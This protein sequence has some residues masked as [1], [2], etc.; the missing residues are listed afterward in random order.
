MFSKKYLLLRWFSK[1][2]RN[3][4]VFQKNFHNLACADFWDTTYTCYCWNDEST[5][6]TFPFD[7]FVTHINLWLKCYICQSIQIIFNAGSSFVFLQ[8]IF[9]PVRIKLISHWFEFHNITAKCNN[10]F[11]KINI[12][13]VRTYIIREWEYKLK[14]TAQ[15]MIHD[16]I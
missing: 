4:F 14:I 11:M 8:N 6:Q 9:V 12:Q 13:N 10:A 5:I 2:T 15:P 1:F 16:V 3:W 7:Q